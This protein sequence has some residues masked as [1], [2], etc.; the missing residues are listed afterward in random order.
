MHAPKHSLVTCGYQP[1]SLPTTTVYAPQYI[2]PM[3]G[4]QMSG[5]SPVTAGPE[6]KAPQ[7]AKILFLVWISREALLHTY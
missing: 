2:A 6:T 4:A 3:P 5:R 7:A 1:C